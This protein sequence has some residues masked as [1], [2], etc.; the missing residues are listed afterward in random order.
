MLK[1]TGKVFGKF[2]NEKT[3][4]RLEQIQMAWADMVISGELWFAEAETTGWAEILNDVAIGIVQFANQYAPESIKPQL[5]FVGFK[6]M[7]Y[8]H[9]LY[10]ASL[11]I[12]ASKEKFDY[13]KDIDE[14]TLTYFAAKVT[15]G[16]G[17]IKTHASE[18]VLKLLFSILVGQFWDA[19][20]LKIF[21]TTVAAHA[22][23]NFVLYG[24]HKLREYLLN[25]LHNIVEEAL[26]P[27]YHIAEKEEE[28]IQAMQ[29]HVKEM[30]SYSF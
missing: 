20:V 5:V 23:V 22:F 14:D 19:S 13:H 12:H 18:I 21:L 24:L 8:A 1:S 27:F 29:L 9:A 6:L 26:E 15:Q 17:F 16:K 2:F 25:K 4:K 7:G 10:Q 28:E 3:T 30:I 11:A